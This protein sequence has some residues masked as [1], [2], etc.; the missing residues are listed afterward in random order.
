M[1]ENHYRIFLKDQDPWAPRSYLLSNT[2]NVYNRVVLVLAVNIY[3]HASLGQR[4]IL[5]YPGEKGT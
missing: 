4:P 2:Q 3:I 5:R 1:I